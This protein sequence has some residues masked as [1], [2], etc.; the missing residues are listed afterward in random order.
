MLVSPRRKDFGAAPP[1]ARSAPF[2]AALG[3][4][5]A[6]AHSAPLSAAT[7]PPPPAQPCSP[8]FAALAQGQAFYEQDHTRRAGHCFDRAVRLDASCAHLV[9]A[10]YLGKGDALASRHQLNQA[11]TAYRTALHYLKILVPKRALQ[12]GADLDARGAEACWQLCKTYEKLSAADAKGYSGHAN[13]CALACASAAL[14]AFKALRPQAPLLYDERITEAYASHFNCLVYRFGRTLTRTRL[15]FRRRFDSAA[16]DAALV[17]LVVLLQRLPAVLADEPLRADCVDYLHCAQELLIHPLQPN[18][19]RLLLDT[20]LPLLRDLLLAKSFATL[21]PDVQVQAL[22]V[23]AT[24]ARKQPYATRSVL[25]YAGAYVATG[26]VRFAAVGPLVDCYRAALEA[27]IGYHDRVAAALPLLHR[28]F[29]T[30]PRALSCVVDLALAV[31]QQHP[32]VDATAPLQAVAA[33][34]AMGTAHTDP[35]FLQGVIDALGYAATTD[36]ALMLSG[37]A[38]LCEVG[39]SLDTPEVPHHQVLRNSIVRLVWPL[40]EEPYPGPVR[41]AVRQAIL[42]RMGVPMPDVLAAMDTEAAGAALPR[43]LDSAELNAPPTYPPS[44]TAP[45]S[46][47]MGGLFEPRPPLRTEGLRSQ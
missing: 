29:F 19:Q 41:Q 4:A 32:L 44:T 24:V 12:A 37:V 8:A 45:P 2:F 11:A 3:A 9:G 39:L 31:I 27:D 18:S 47:R 21:G 30:T 38:A 13:D 6:Q 17:D 35:E 22:Q 1:Q 23:L 26:G 20:L 28:A 14:A 16:L 25:R 10:F 43:I 33:L 36:D 40:Q 15:P 42:E 46:G 5:S 7:G 34:Q